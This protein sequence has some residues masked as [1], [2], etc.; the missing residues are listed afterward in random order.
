MNMPVFTECQPY[1]TEIGKQFVS[2]VLQ[3]AVF[4]DRI[5]TAGRIL[6]DH[7]ESDDGTLVTVLVI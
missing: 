1:L 2:N 6:H 4:E 3:N 7:L 5:V